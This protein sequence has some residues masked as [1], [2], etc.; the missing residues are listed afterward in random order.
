LQQL[1]LARNSTYTH[2]I[3]LATMVLCAAI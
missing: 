2:F 3:T 1:L